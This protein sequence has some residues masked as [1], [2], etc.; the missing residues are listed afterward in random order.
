MLSQHERYAFIGE[1]RLYTFRNYFPNSIPKASDVFGQ[2]LAAYAKGQ[3]HET[4]HGTK[5]IKL[6]S[7]SITNSGFAEILFKLTDPSIPDN[8]L[9]D[10]T[11]D[12]LRTAARK[13]NED[14]A[15]SAHVLI[16]LSQAHDQNKLYPMCIEN[17]DF[18][19]RSLMIGYFNEWLGGTY[20]KTMDR[21]EKKDKKL[22]SPRVEFV[23]PHSHT[24]QDALDNGG[25]LTGVK[26]VEDKMHQQSFGDKAYPIEQRNDV[27]ITVRNRPTGAA[28]KKIL[29]D[30]FD[31][32]RGK[33]PKS[34]K[35]T[36]VDSN[37]RT[38]TIGIDPSKN[39]VLSNVF[40]PQVLMNG[41]SK[42]MA[43]CEPSIRSDMIS[44]MKSALK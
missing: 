28:A 40:I 6:S 18:L 22:F 2:L 7:F 24:I 17:I 30:T 34:F 13:K 32:S 10:R 36:I 19:P 21:K 3:S 5:S 38:K 25:V 44:K 4:T 27:G 43:M 26:W 42:P 14:P 16:D 23:A 41:F 9:S 39:N 31:R 33:K 15:I 11:N 20:T 29:I 35:V 12:S 1:L 8:V 37:E